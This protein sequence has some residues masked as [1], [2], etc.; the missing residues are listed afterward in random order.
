MKC[1]VQRLRVDV[2]KSSKINFRGGDRCETGKPYE[3]LKQL[4]LPMT[5]EIRV[6]PNPK[7]LESV[8]NQLRLTCA[9][10]RPTPGTD[11]SC[12][13]GCYTSAEA[14]N[15]T[16]FF[17][18]QSKT[19]ERQVF[20][21]SSTATFTRTLACV[22][23]R[24]HSVWHCPETTCAYRR[25]QVMNQPETF[26]EHMLPTAQCVRVRPNSAVVKIKNSWM[27]ARYRTEKKHQQKTTDK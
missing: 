20:R 22:R 1:I 19:G 15:S 8:A 18:N 9:K 16:T 7:Y 17:T 2:R 12:D 6:Q 21:A 14:L 23:F 25:R 13:N 4:R 3:H 10:T 26:V 11:T 5:G 27:D 24:K